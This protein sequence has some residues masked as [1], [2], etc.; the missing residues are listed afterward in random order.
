MSE[1]KYEKKHEE[2]ND[3]IS[4]EK[5][6]EIDRREGRTA[7]GKSDHEVQGFGL[8]EKK[9]GKYHPNENTRKRS[10]S[11]GQIA[12]DDMVSELIKGL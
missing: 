9:V 12:F 7:H 8:T 3:R 11:G 6:A 5:P 4:V 10:A 1:Y 2:S